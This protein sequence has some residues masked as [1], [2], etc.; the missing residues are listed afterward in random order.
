[1]PIR[2]L[3]LGAALLA[4]SLATLAGPPAAPVRDVTQTLHGV[5]VHDPY[6]DLEDVKS[7][8]TL[9]WLKAQ[10]AYAESV[11]ATMPERDKLAARID[12]LAR[13]TGESVRS[14]V[15]LPGE[16][17]FYLKREAGHS[18]F[19]LMAR[20]GLAGAERVLVDPEALTKAKG[21]PHAINYF[22]PSW[23]G[24]RV[25]YGMSAGGSEDA[26][27]YLL[28]VASGQAIGEPIPRVHENLVHWTPDSRQLTYN[29]VRALPPDA[30]PTETY[31]DSTVFVLRA[32]ALE[33]QAK[34][35]FGPLVDKN[36]KLDRL[37][38]AGVMFDPTSRF[39]LA[40]TTDTTVPEGKLFVGPVSE[41]GKPKIAWRQVSAFDDRITDVQLYR[42]TLYLRTT[43]DAPRGRWLALD[44]GKAGPLAS[45]R[46]AIEEPTK[47]VLKGLVVGRGGALYAE[48]SEGFTTRT[49]KFGSGPAPLDVAPGSAGSSFAI[50]DPAHAYGEAWLVSS[51]WTGQPK[52]LRSRGGDQ[53][54]VDT[55]LM[56]RRM[57]PG[58]P[59]LTVSEVLVPSH[60]GA[61]VPLAILHRADLK[62]G[63]P[64]PTLLVGYGAYGFSFEAFFDSRS[65]AWLERGGVIAYANVRG[66]GAFGDGWHRAGFK[67]T[68]SNTW[69]DGIACA[70]YL[71]DQG[72][73]TP[74]TLGIWGTSAGGI[75]VGRSVTAAPDLF[76]AAVFD[77][78]MMDTI[79]SE[80]SANGITNI[81]EFGTVKDPEEF[82]ALLDMSTYHQIKDGVAY[83]AVLLIHGLNDP[84]V[85]VWQSG[86]A[87]A[88]LQAASYSGKPVL[89]RLDGQA[90][91]GVGSTLQQQ[92]SK[93][94][95]VYAFLLWQFS[96][97]PA[98]ATAAASAPAKP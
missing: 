91:H 39:M 25:A 38:V 22:V 8:A 5:T 43:K 33:K 37:D 59:E 89:L 29:Q 31:L 34:P 82:K 15:R 9:D 72:Y 79:R 57:P 80:E 20:T 18:Q 35:L 52:I 24:K 14:V 70:K 76:A 94:A 75:F 68:K 65:V 49:Y 58:T 45:A 71:V 77:V 51:S 4:A 50:D 88:R 78:G 93:L 56:Q 74:K 3:S 64:H 16:K 55:L 2:Q 19:K 11:L 96:Q 66:S 1:M 6:R 85:D 30:A 12:E 69:K 44:L 28:D 98:T 63:E 73:A 26:S 92:V 41:L 60:D 21:A 46:V 61:Q 87:A 67:T 10:G 32:G 40:R 7:P 36:L 53:A 47:G 90:G 42:D 83:P 84:R 95:D 86:K 81:S 23:D 13:A 27:L 97:P 17:L 54:P 48:V 62:R